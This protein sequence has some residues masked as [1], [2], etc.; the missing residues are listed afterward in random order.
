MNTFTDRDGRS[1]DLS[2]NVGLLARV[3]QTTGIELAKALKSEQALAEAIFAEPEKLV[4][5]LYVICEAQAQKAGISPEQFGYGFDGEA[6]E[7]ATQAM[8]ESIADFF[9]RSAL[10]RAVKSRLPQILARADREMVSEAEKRLDSILSEN[11]G[12]SPASP[13]SIPAR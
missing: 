7:R 5:V 2:L 4:E 1:W 3:R 12:G 6:L 9:P 13:A 10:A 11:A 8:L